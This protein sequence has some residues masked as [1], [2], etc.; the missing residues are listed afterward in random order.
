MS[1]RRA[2]AAIAFATTAASTAC[3]P[4][5][6]GAFQCTE[7][8]Q[9]GVGGACEANGLC[10]F[11]DATCPSGRRYGEAS[12]DLAGVCV[13]DEPPDAAIPDAPVG[14]DAPPPI[15]GE[16]DG[17]PPPPFCD[18]ADAT[19]RL[20][21]PF[22]GDAIDGSGGA[23]TVTT[24]SIS[25]AAGQVGQAVVVDTASRLDIA[26]TPALDF[27]HMT[28]EAWI[29]VT[30]PGS[31]RSG[32]VDNN[33]QYGFFI[34]PN[35]DLRCT[36]AGTVTVPAAV[37]NGTWTHVACTYDGTTEIV[38]VNG[39]PAGMIVS[40]GSISTTGTQGTS[41]GGDNPPGP[42]RLVGMI[43]QF[44]MYSE[45]RTPVQI[46]QAAGTCP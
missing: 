24:T 6:G 45:A 30:L 34:Y 18:P 17:S 11:A 21:L 36:P 25:F 10:S 13:G 15:D 26:E 12:G 23:L 38:Y 2:A 8:A 46:C 31:A 39:T 42:D 43:D 3:S 19:L 4:F 33:G 14:D 20:C 40:P 27:G 29:N 5:G 28:I 7:S 22:E 41:I 37:A 32:V 16:I 9:C 35:G 1:W 44:R